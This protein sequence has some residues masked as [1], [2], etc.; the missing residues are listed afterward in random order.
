MFYLNWNMR[1][2]SVKY[3][4]LAGGVFLL[5]VVLVLFTS[6]FLPLERVLLDG[7][8]TIVWRYRQLRRDPLVVNTQ[9][10]GPSEALILAKHADEFSSSMLIRISLPQGTRITSEKTLIGFVSESFGSTSKVALITAPAAKINGVFNRSGIP[11]EFE[12]KGAG[13]LEADLPKGSDVRTEDTVFYA[14]DAELV[15]GAVLQ[16]KDNPASPFINILVQS[17]INTT[18]LQVVQYGR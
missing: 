16:V 8:G 1:R 3:S 17:P 15:I 14:E 12:G 5:A 4:Y 9:T 10:L 2:R 6:V 18:V 11:A 13:F 7:A